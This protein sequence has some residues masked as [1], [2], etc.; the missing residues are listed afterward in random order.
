MSRD[1]L[2]ANRFRAPRIPP[3]SLKWSDD[4]CWG[5]FHFNARCKRAIHCSLKRNCGKQ[6]GTSPY[7]CSY[8]GVRPIVAQGIPSVFPTPLGLLAK[9]MLVNVASPKPTLPAKENEIRRASLTAMDRAT[10]PSQ[11]RG[12]N[13]SISSSAAMIWLCARSS[14]GCN[15]A[16][17]SEISA[18]S[19]RKVGITALTAS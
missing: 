1:D 6:S 13:R 4:D 5:S 16:T 15:F 11:K 2:S 17:R 8:A 7:C 18:K 14:Q 10:T 12:A 19:R 3:G 9:V